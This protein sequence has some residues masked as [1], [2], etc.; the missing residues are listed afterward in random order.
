MLLLMLKKQQLLLLE[1]KYTLVILQY[2]GMHPYLGNQLL[3]QPLF[4]LLLL[5]VAYL[6]IVSWS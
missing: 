3:L 6:S 4:E 2:I 1:P 5:L